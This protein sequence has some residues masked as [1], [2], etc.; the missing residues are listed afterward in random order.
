MKTNVSIEPSAGAEASLSRALEHTKKGINMSKITAQEK[1]EALQHAK[2][3]LK[4]YFKKYHRSTGI[5]HALPGTP[6][7]DYLRKYIMGLING[8]SF[9]TT[10]VLR[11]VYGGDWIAQKVVGIT[12]DTF[13]QKQYHLYR[14]RWIDHLINQIKEG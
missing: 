1:I 14:L 11:K 5:C 7:G 9:V 13:W 12:S 4:T 3:R 6:A 2:R 10:W 8:S